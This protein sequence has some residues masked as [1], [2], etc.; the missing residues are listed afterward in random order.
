[1]GEFILQTRYP[2]GTVSVSV[3]R[4]AHIIERYGFRD[5]TDC[6]FEVFAS[7]G[8]GEIRKLEYVPAMS[9]PFNFHQFIDP[10]TGEVV[11]EGYSTE[12]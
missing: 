6:D 7:V 9:A 1:M 5:C 8:F 3:E 10:V 4:E 11:F 12:H 2:D